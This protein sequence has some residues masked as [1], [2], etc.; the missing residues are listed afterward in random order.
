M[1]NNK[2]KLKIAFANGT[3]END[4]VKYLS[5]RY[6]VEVVDIINKSVGLRELPNLIVFTG[7]ADVSPSLYGENVGSRTYVNADRDQ[8]EHTTYGRYAGLVPLLGI[9]RGA[10]LLT[11]LNRGSLIQ[12]TNGHSMTNH[13]ISSL[14]YHGVYT[15][16]GDH[17][18]MM[19]PFNLDKS[20]YE[21]LYHSHMFKSS[22]YLNG[23]NEE[24]ELPSFFVE[25]EIVFYPKSKALCIQGHPEWMDGTH[26]TVQMTLN[27]I[28][29]K[30]FNNKPIV[31]Y[32]GSCDEDFSE[33]NDEDSEDDIEYD[34][35]ES[36]EVDE[37]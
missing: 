34:N 24:I 4:Y 29:D 37:L 17:H 30:L 31:N 1:E 33:E 32:S 3:T 19:Y 16:N 26:P 13:T 21:I 15:I 27:L 35:D 7:G 11:V 23:N 20:S 12:H 22:T 28:A 6:D 18:Q 9:C 10:Q 2:E 14:S 36:G 5:V 25:P 8:I